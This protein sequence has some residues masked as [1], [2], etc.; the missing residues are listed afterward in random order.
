MKHKIYLL[1]FLASGLLHLSANFYIPANQNKTVIIENNTGDYSLQQIPSFLKWGTV[2]FSLN[3]F[4]TK[5]GFG[6][7]TNESRH[8]SVL[9]VGSDKA[10]FT[11]NNNYVILNDHAYQLLYTPVWQDGEL[12][13]PA[14]MLV[15]LFN[16]F[17]AHRFSFDIKEQI[18]TL[19]MKDVNL[20]G[21][22]IVSKENGTLIT[23]HS[24]K[25]FT[26]RIS[27]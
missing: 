26:K 3:D 18:F 9:Y 1:V 12:W 8:K 24:S 16:N 10:T 6:I 11:S 19:G 23:V 4:A 20:T 21:V 15:D 7:Y 13:V 17:T 2:Y 27:R 22:K 5:T 25:Q 14:M